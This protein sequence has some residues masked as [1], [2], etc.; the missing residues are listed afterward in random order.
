M[1]DYD[2][3]VIG[4][5]VV[6]TS[7]VLALAHLPL[8]IALVEQRAFESA[9]PPALKNKP[10]ALNYASIHILQTLVPWS[11]LSVHANPIKMVHVSEQGRFAAARI[12]A[13]EMGVT[14]LGYVIPATQLN[15]VCTEALLQRATVSKNEKYG[16]DLYNPAQCKALTKTTNGWEILI[17]TPKNKTA[18]TIHARLLIVADGSHS[19]T[20]NLLGIKVKKQRVEQRALSATLS[21]ARHH[22]Y[23][24][25]QRFT[26]EGV[27]ACLPLSENNVG[28]IWTAAHPFIDEL[29]VCAEFD[30]LARLQSIFSYHLGKFVTS[31]PRCVYS[32]KSFIAELQAKPGLVLLGNAAHTLSPI[33]AQ[34]LNLALLDMV[35]LVDI[36]IQ[37]V[38][39]NK[40]LADPWISQTYLTNRL[41]PQRRSIGF[42]ENL[43]SVF[44]LRFIPLTLLRSSALLAFD[45]VPFF[46]KNISRRLMGIHGRFPAWLTT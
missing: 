30:F 37:A 29:S 44:R 9:D 28:I 43:A 35:E 12:K 46:K 34:G 25:H 1:K 4:A 23:T 21:L 16:I 3:L 15:K 42:T 6:G 26:R 33:A 19:V 7:L 13:K 36:L 22:H 20:R 10:I 24:A 32:T 39:E 31:G 40:D 11:A 14:A 5:G 38:Y 18:L 2:I 8:R 27:V 17:T 45:L 41:P